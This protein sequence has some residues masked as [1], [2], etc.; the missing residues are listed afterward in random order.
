MWIRIPGYVATYISFSVQVIQIISLPFRRQDVNFLSIC[1]AHELVRMQLQKTTN[2]PR[3]KTR[4]GTGET[5]SN[6]LSMYDITYHTPSL[7][8]RRNPNP[9]QV[10]TRS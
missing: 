9:V 1:I 10:S 4:V 6:I 8:T 5:L 3:D 2:T 7:R